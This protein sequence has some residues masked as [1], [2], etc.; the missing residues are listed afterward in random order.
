MACLCGAIDCPSCGPTQGWHVCNTFCERPCPL[1]VEFVEFVDDDEDDD[2][3]YSQ[4][5]NPGT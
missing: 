4:I 5:S 2:I 1:L 3:R